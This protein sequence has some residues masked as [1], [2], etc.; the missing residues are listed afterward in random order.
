[1]DGWDPAVKTFKNHENLLGN[2]INSS[3][4]NKIKISK[5]QRKS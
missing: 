1:M 3:N 4:G 5:N 2:T